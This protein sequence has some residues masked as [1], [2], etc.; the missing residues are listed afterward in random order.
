MVKMIERGTIVK[1]LLRSDGELLRSVELGTNLFVGL[2]RFQMQVEPI[3]RARAV[4]PSPGKAICSWQ[5]KSQLVGSA[6][7]LG[8]ALGGS[9]WGI[10]SCS[11]SF[12]ADWW[13]TNPGAVMASDS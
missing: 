2:F 6:Q 12:R 4:A 9:N 3:Q 1:H 5:R 7:P 11:P 8:V 13:A 10:F